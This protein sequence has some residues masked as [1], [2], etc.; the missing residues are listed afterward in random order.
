MLSQRSSRPSHKKFFFIRQ[1]YCVLAWLA[2]KVTLCGLALTANW[3]RTPTKKTMKSEH[4]LSSHC[5]ASFVILPFTPICPYTFYIFSFVY[6]RLLATATSM[7]QEAEQHFQISKRYSRAV[8]LY[9][10]T[11]GS[12][13][14]R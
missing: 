3:S 6:C 14:K 9:V 7:S 8:S 10:F 12:V 13:Y 11:V 2:G 5:M 1:I 4:N